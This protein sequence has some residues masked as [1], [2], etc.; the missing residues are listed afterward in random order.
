VGVTGYTPTPPSQPSPL[1]ARTTR[2]RQASAGLLKGQDRSR[3]D[4]DLDLCGCARLRCAGP[5]LVFPHFYPRVDELLS[6]APRNG[7]RTRH[8]ATLSLVGTRPPGQHRAEPSQLNRHAEV[9]RDPPPVFTSERLYQEGRPVQMVKVRFTARVRTD[10]SEANALDLPFKDECFDQIVSTFAM[11]HWPDRELGLSEIKRVLVPGGTA[12]ITEYNRDYTD[13]EYERFYKR[14]KAVFGKYLSTLPT[15]P[16]GVRWA[17]KQGLS[18]DEA[19]DIARNVGFREI[20][21]GRIE[22]W[23][24]LKLM[25][26]K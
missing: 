8:L 10:F 20:S 23:P 15:T 9:A 26:K 19:A 7:H 2:F 1:N 17:V 5:R 21:A 18:P 24:Y 3:A 6:R 12:F 13:E 16:I 14:G 11:K 25:L 4:K 22:G